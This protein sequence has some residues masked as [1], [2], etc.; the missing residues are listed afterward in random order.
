MNHF[1]LTRFFAAFKNENINKFSISHSAPEVSFTDDSKIVA[2]FFIFN[3]S[4]I[5]N[6]PIASRHFTYFL[7]VSG[8]LDF[9]LLSP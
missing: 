3:F 5:I 2:K 7:V 1:G 9:F 8:T 6:I 4:A